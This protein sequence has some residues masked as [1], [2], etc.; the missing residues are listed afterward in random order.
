MLIGCM[1][2]NPNVVSIPRDLLKQREC[3]ATHRA[4]GLQLTAKAR[5]SINSQVLSIH[6]PATPKQ[7]QPLGDPTLLTR[8]TGR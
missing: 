4:L 6:C 7:Q 2:Q 1:D 5:I 8:W 3:P